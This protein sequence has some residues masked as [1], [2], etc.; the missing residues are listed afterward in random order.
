MNNKL[1]YTFIRVWGQ[2][3]SVTNVYWEYVMVFLGVVF[4]NRIPLR[5]A[6]CSDVWVCDSL[7][8]QIRTQKSLS[9]SETVW[10]SFS[11]NPQFQDSAVKV[12]QTHTQT[13]TSVLLATP[14]T[15][16]SLQQGLRYNTQCVV[17][18]S[19]FQLS[20]CHLLYNMHTTPST[21]ITVAV[22]HCSFIHSCGGLHVWLGTASFFNPLAPSLPFPE[23]LVNHKSTTLIV[24][25][26]G[27]IQTK[28]T[29]PLDHI[30]AFLRQC[31]WL[32]C[33]LPTEHY[34]CFK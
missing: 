33:S 13:L 12:P 23:G 20:Q 29:P 24:Q 19:H 1:L 5:W 17:Y 22:V 34:C 10:K 14:R 4:C 11:S 26:S 31:H 8:K 30:S 27:F 9:F 32:N 15:D 3:S 7:L 25:H 16:I 6:Q 28:G 21:E 2:K 18:E